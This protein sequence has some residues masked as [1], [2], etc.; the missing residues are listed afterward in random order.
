MSSPPTTDTSNRAGTLHRKEIT[1][2]FPLLSTF[3]LFHKKPV[4]QSLHIREPYEVAPGIWSTDATAKV[5]GYLDSDN[6]KLARIGSQG[7]GPDDHQSL[8]QTSKRKPRRRTR[9]FIGR[10]IEAHKDDET[11]EFRD[12]PY[13]LHV[14]AR[15][16]SREAKLEDARQQR[17]EN[18]RRNRRGRMRTV[19]REDELIER[20]ANPRT[21][22]VS[23]FVT[24]EDSSRVSLETDYIAVGRAHAAKSGPKPNVSTSRWKQ[25]SA[26]WSIVESPALSPIAQSISESVSRQVSVKAAD[27]ELVNDPETSDKTNEDI[28]RYQQSVEQARNCSDGVNAL[29]DPYTL[30]SPRQLTPEAPITPTKKL[31]R[32]PRKDVGTCRLPRQ[33][34][35]ETVVVSSN[36]RSQSLPSIGHGTRDHQQV[37]IITPSQTAL[38]QP[39]RTPLDEKSTFLGQWPGQSPTARAAISRPTVLQQDHLRPFPRLQDPLASLS[40]QPLTS[41]TLNQSLPRLHLAHPSQISSIAASSYRRPAQLLPPR[42]RPPKEKRQAIENACTITTTTTTTSM[43]QK[44]QRQKLQRQ[45]SINNRRADQAHPNRRAEGQYLRQQTMQLVQGTAGKVLNRPIPTAS[46]RTSISNNKT[47]KSS[48]QAPAEARMV[49][50]IVNMGGAEATAKAA[51]LEE[52]CIQEVKSG[53][54]PLKRGLG[55]RDV[56]VVRKAG[57]QDPVTD[58]VTRTYDHSGEK[59]GDAKASQ[60]PVEVIGKAQQHSTELGEGGV[61]VIDNAPLQLETR[62]SLARRK[63]LVEKAAVAKRWLEDVESWLQSSVW[64]AWAQLKLWDMSSHVFYTLRCASPALDILRS[65]KGTPSEYIKAMKDVILAAFYL[66]LLTNFCMTLGRA[67]LV[68]LTA[69]Y[70]FSHPFL[71]ISKVLKWYLLG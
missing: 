36:L 35:N 32:I 10:I 34:S 57:P 64:V 38:G 2:T 67:A 37:R 8:I 31:W 33:P 12:H 19:S 29:V 16:R 45:G 7:T 51:M 63:S 21:G 4:E 6:H 70:L 30:P 44:D 50:N 13:R 5:F 58:G 66:L 59:P 43:P 24:S 71:W 42:L 15:E 26:G 48:Q 18:K 23:P 68:V 69:V 53:W 28:L 1:S 27:D 3:N 61:C 41:P 56:D 9:G 14:E 62:C 22:I 46:V 52:N 65:S 20:A 60:N 17:E 47:L 49:E 55:P 54:H 39:P 11:D 25:D 40:N